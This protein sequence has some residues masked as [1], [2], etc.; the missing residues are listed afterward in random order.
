MKKNKSGKILN[1]ALIILA[2]CIVAIG[3]VTHFIK[4]NNAES[5]DLTDLTDKLVITNLDV[6]KADAAIIE[7]NGMCGIID[8]G[9]KDSYSTIADYLE[10]KQITALD[11]MI[12]THYDKD[13][14]GSAVKLL[15]NYAVTN[16]YLPSYVSS[17]SGYYKLME[18]IEGNDNVDY[19]TEEITIEK[20]EL[21]ICIIPPTNPAELLSSEKDM[22]NDMSLLCMLT[23]G[24]KNFLFTGDIEETRISQILS[25]GKDLSADW[26]KMPHHGA[27][28]DNLSD[29]L[30]IVSP[31]YAIIS[32]GPER[33]T[34][35]NVLSILSKLNIQKYSTINGSVL[36]I[37]DG[38]EITVRNI[39]NAP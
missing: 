26:I 10:E 4:K 39:K 1:I 25:S 33:P 34:E 24:N 29:F 38:N 19:I 8:T 18:A 32:T 21:K 11:F 13:H 17:K 16:V 12:I 37:C 9:T 5:L 2:F 7:Y 15:K 30:A 28:K 31:S 23:F 35:S 20:D 3:L 27:Y 14:V 36:T 22:D 6:G